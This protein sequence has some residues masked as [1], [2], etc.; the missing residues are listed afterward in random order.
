[1]ERDTLNKR[2]TV[3]VYVDGESLERDFFFNEMPDEER[4]GEILHDL[5]ETCHQYSIE[6]NKL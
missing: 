5:I 6:E 2:V 1:M 4:C 3:L